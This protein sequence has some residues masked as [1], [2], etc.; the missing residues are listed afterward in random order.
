MIDG[1]QVL[2][3]IVSGGIA[4]TIVGI[5]SQHYSDK[6]L[7]RYNLI[8]ESQFRAFSEL[9][10]SLM[11][12]KR[13][14]DSLGDDVNEKDLSEF[15]KYIAEAHISL[16]D[17]SLILTKEDYAN[18]KRILDKFWQY[19]IGKEKIIEMKDKKI[20]NKI[21]Y[22]SGAIAISNER[23]NQESSNDSIKKEYENLLDDLRE[24]FQKKREIKQ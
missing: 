24:S 10:K 13:K 7:A 22:V 17:N 12:L 14:G 11:N 8:N 16:Q 9:W 1:L 2:G 19:K 4:G 21:F 3:W 6:K 5:I 15:V 20:Q 18:L 23:W